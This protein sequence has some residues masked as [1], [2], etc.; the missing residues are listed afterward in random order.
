MKI[1]MSFVVTKK[2]KDF[3]QQVG[4]HTFE[5]GSSQFKKTIQ[6]WLTTCLRIIVKDV[7]LL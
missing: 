3:P 7:V 1:V 6:A 5:K 2:E 4:F